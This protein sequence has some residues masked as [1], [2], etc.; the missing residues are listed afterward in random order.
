VESDE[1]HNEFERRFR[2]GSY[3]PQL[4]VYGQIPESPY[5]FYME[6][7]NRS[8]VAMPLALVGQGKKKD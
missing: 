6:D 1:V 4:N 5:W 7:K 2:G 3:L 8:C